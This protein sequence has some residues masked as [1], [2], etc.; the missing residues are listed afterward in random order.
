MTCAQCREL[1]DA[2]IDGELPSE[3]D[4]GRARAHRVVRGVR[5]MNTRRSSRRRGESE[6]RS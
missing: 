1:L 5:A 2:Y 3:D 4:G 6:R